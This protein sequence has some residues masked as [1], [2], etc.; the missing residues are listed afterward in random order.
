MILIIII[1]INCVKICASYSLPLKKKKTNSPDFLMLSFLNDFVKFFRIRRSW[2]ACFWLFKFVLKLNTISLKTN[3]I[4]E[5]FYWHLLI[6]TRWRKVTRWVTGKAMPILFSSKTLFSSPT[7]VAIGNPP[8][9]KPYFT[10]LQPFKFFLY[11]HSFL[12]MVQSCIYE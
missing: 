2:S 11:L 4:A 5:F 1:Q 12:K 7:L 10:V 9:T 3:S 8:P 6:L